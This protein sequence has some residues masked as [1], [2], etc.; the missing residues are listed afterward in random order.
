MHRINIINQRMRVNPGVEMH[1]KM[2][3]CL[4][5]CLINIALTRMLKQQLVQCIKCVQ[6]GQLRATTLYE[7]SVV[8]LSWPVQGSQAKSQTEA[9]MRH[10]GSQT[11]TSVEEVTASLLLTLRITVHAD[12]LDNCHT[13]R[14]YRKILFWPFCPYLRQT[15][16]RNTQRQPKVTSISTMFLLMFDVTPSI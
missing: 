8:A 3:Y 5:W 12:M 15:N 6:S 2:I 11:R 13:P 7:Y 9:E 10:R 4:N 1:C 14:V 16:C